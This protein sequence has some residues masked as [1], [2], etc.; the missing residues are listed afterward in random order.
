MVLEKTLENPL[1]SKEIKPVHPK[2]NQPWI[3]TGRTD[4]EAPILWPSEA[5][6]RLIGKDW[7]LERIEGRWR[8]GWQ[9]MRWL[10]GIIDSMDMS[11]SKLREMVKDRE[12][13]H[14]TVHGVAKTQTWLSD[15]TTVEVI[16]S[17]RNAFHLYL[18]L[19]SREQCTWFKKP[20]S[21]RATSLF[22]GWGNGSPKR[23]SDLPKAAQYYSSGSKASAF[24][25]CSFH[26]SEL[27]SPQTPHFTHRDSSPWEYVLR[28]WQFPP[29]SSVL[30]IMM[31]L[32]TF[33]LPCLE[34]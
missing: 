18:H 12:A 15:W 29:V 9:R 27:C 8:R 1:D 3:F 23:L 5:K 22:Y 16:V 11:F 17:I 24:L 32:I 21:P 26:S 20:H 2:R 19:A 25:H 34:T 4:A 14:G 6:S 10:D 28:F 7:M 33:E 30:G 31:Y 13:W